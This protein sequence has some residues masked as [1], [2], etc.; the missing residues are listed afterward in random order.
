MSSPDLNDTQMT[1]TAFKA[2]ATRGAAGPGSLYVHFT[3]LPPLPPLY[4][5]ST[6]SDA[7][8]RVTV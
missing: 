8:H 3:F 7:Q 1:S 2:A 4:S 5:I 6:I